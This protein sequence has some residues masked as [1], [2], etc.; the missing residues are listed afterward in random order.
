VLE[1]RTK[2]DFSKGPVWDED[3]GR[4]C[5][6]IRC[7][8]GSRKRKRFRRER[9]AMRWW[10]AEIRKI[11]EGTWAAP[12]P[13]NV[14]LGD[15][16]DKYRKHAQ[17]HQRSFKEFTDPMLR[18][19]EREFGRGTPLARVTTSQ[20]EQIKLKRAQSVAPATCDKTVGVL[21]CAFNWAISQGLAASNP[22]RG[23]KFFN[24]NNQRLRYLAEDEEQ[25]LLA[26]AD[27]GPR[28]LTPMIK[29]A[30]NLGLRWGNLSTLRWE[31]IDS[32]AGVIRKTDTK[33][34]ETLTVPVNDT[35]RAVLKALEGTR[36][37]SPY[38]F[39]HLNGPNAGREIR[40]VKRSFRRALERAGINDFRWHDLRHTFASK[41]VMAG[42]DLM[43]VQR[44]LGHK[45]LRM[46]QRYAHLSHRYL[47]DQIRIL[48][49]IGSAKVCPRR[50]PKRGHR[51]TS[52]AKSGIRSRRVTMANLND[53]PLPSKSRITSASRGRTNRIRFATRGS[54]VRA[55]SGPPCHPLR[56]HW[57]STLDRS[58]AP[59]NLG[60]EGSKTRAILLAN[61][62][63][64]S[65]I[66]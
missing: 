23:I 54:G 49:K 3:L 2:R 16:F 38:V 14:T 7:P 45:T 43:A 9:A 52:Q 6:E 21:R 51:A 29:L 40:S 19:W 5:V 37:D 27:K 56:F 25:R 59:C 20:I 61:S 55:P 41:L 63:C 58:F 31:E 57:I 34:K 50:A 17:A 4:F 33:N 1:T 60:A 12:A 44:F 35:A 18:F 42:A 48:D 66:G 10:V 13:K 53:L 24:P 28:H 46:T 22:V 11:D 8:D 36:T 30:L 62:R 64:A 26:E 15:A 47:A 32:H 65:G 39:H